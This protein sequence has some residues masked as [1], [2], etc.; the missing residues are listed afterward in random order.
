M[1]ALG[2]YL[3]DGTRLAYVANKQLYL[4]SMDQLEAQPVPGTDAITWS[5]SFRL[6][7]LAGVFCDDR[8]QPRTLMKIAVLRWPAT[9][10]RHTAHGRPSGATW[11]NG[12]IAFAVTTGAVH[13]VQAIA[14]SGGPLQTIATVDAEKEHINQ[15]RLLDDGKHILFVV[16]SVKYSQCN[17][18]QIVVSDSG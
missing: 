16:H 12:M 13:A 6:T 8:H 17:E 7:A 4:R 18:G 3:P 15:P 14:D 5:P 10:S 1:G 11:N 9:D 2:G